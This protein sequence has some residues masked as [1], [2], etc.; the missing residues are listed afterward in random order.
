MRKTDVGRHK[1]E[2]VENGFTTVD[3]I[4]TDQEIELILLTIDQADKTKETFRKSVDLFAIRQFFKEIPETTNLV[5]N[6]NLK[7]SITQIFGDD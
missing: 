6:D 5:F 3:N 7:N 2:I 1:I 4:F